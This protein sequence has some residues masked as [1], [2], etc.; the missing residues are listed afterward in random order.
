M[1][2]GFAIEGADKRWTWSEGRI[3][4]DEIALWS[5][6]VPRPTGV[7]YAWADNPIISIVNAAGLP[8]RPF[9]TDKEQP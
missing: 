6:A 7:R 8:L 9:R 4:G 1:V 2:R 5:P 3:E